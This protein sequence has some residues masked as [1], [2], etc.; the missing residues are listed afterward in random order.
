[1][2][3]G[4]GSDPP[5]H[6]RSGAGYEDGRGRRRVDEMIERKRNE[7]STL[8]ILGTKNGLMIKKCRIIGQVVIPKRIFIRIIF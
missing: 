2:A 3:M 6:L 1:M 7:K 5:A 4:G 8:R